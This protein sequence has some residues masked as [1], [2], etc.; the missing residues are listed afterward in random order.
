VLYF[1]SIGI[2]KLRIGER[3]FSDCSANENVGL[4][5]SKNLYFPMLFWTLLFVA[6]ERT[7]ITVTELYVNRI[8]CSLQVRC[9]TRFVI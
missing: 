8:A 6:D 3:K 9:R 1:K 7:S 5:K 2:K 4:I